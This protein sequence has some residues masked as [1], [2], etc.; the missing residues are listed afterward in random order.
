VDVVQQRVVVHVA[1]SAR[2]GRPRDAAVQTALLA[3]SRR[4]SSG[5][6]RRGR[7]ARSDVHERV[8]DL[9]VVY[10][11][12]AGRHGPSCCD[13]HS[14]KE[15]KLTVPITGTGPST[16]TW[17]AIVPVV[18][19]S[20]GVGV[21]AGGAAPSPH[22]TASANAASAARDRG[23]REPYETVDGGSTRAREYRSSPCPP[24]DRL[25]FGFERMP[26][27]KVGSDEHTQVFCREFVD[28]HH[29]SPG[30]V[31]GRSGAGRGRAAPQPP[32]LGRATSERPPRPA[33]AYA[34][35]DL[36]RSCARPSR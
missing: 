4:A 36:T 34:D 32:V 3:R 7:R 33:C 25:L 14:P 21:R 15:P 12:I 5:S 16:T 1:P 10:H 9:T 27:L 24:W 17:P 29:T 26:H 19:W 22:A 6:R 20:I 13:A 18:V 35:V 23:I 11:K 28:T 2:P 8:L 30:S 31:V